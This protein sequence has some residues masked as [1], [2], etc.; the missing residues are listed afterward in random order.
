MVNTD[1][2]ANIPTVIKKIN[3]INSCLVKEDEFDT[4]VL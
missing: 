3:Y 4:L 1:R 2:Y